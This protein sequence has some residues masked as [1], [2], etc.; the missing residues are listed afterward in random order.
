MEIKI[1]QNEFISENDFIDALETPTSKGTDIKIAQSFVN[2]IEQELN[3][4]SMI[5]KYVEK[6]TEF[7]NEDFVKLLNKLYE[8]SL[9]EYKDYN[10]IFSL[11]LGK[12]YTQYHRDLIYTYMTR[13]GKYASFKG[14]GGWEK[15]GTTFRI[16]HSDDFHHKGSRYTK[17]KIKELVKNGQIILLEEFN[18]EVPF[19]ESMKEYYEEFEV[20]HNYK[21]LNEDNFFFPYIIAYLKQEIPNEK[22]LKDIYEYL[23]NLQS[24]IDRVLINIENLK[25]LKTECKKELDKNHILT[26]LAN[27]INEINKKIPRNND[28]QKLYNTLREIISSK[29]Y[30]MIVKTRDEIALEYGI[31]GRETKKIQFENVSEEDFWEFVYQG[32]MQINPNANINFHIVNGFGNVHSSVNIDIN[33]LV[34]VI[35]LNNNHKYD[36]WIDDL[37]ATK[38]VD[39]SKPLTRIRKKDN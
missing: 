20:H 21:T 37:A 25:G 34:S 29:E 10:K 14:E 31:I 19:P 4:A 13:R 8:I 5:L 18:D 33:E 28:R 23:I 22:I 39:L 27:M 15:I 7:S 26:R 11:A 6:E 35:I 9:D 12:T 36:K 3:T 30:T 17:N 24:R 38:K 16:A 32:I 2:E 1:K